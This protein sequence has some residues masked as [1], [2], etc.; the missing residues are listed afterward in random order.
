MAGIQL[1][2]KGGQLGVDG[3]VTGKVV[4]LASDVVAIA[5]G[6]ILDGSTG[7]E[8]VNGSCTGLKLHGLVLGTRDRHAD[9]AH[10]LVQTGE[11]LI[12]TSLSLSRRVGGLDGLLPRAE[13]IHTSLETRMSFS[14]SACKVAC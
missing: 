3:M 13:G 5:T 10:L 12:D 9:V 6:G 1:R 11:G 14:S 8:F 4:E 2:L 7:H